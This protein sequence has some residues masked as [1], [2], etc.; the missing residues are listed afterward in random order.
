VATKGFGSVSVP[1][2]GCAK[3]EP[4]KG[5]LSL[6]ARASHQGESHKCKTERH[7]SLNLGKSLAESLFL[8]GYSLGTLVAKNIAR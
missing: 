5:R 1:V 7:F 6:L 8:L 4:S 2:F 3:Y